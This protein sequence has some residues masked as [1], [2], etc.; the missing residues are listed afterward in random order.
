MN[1]VAFMT[2]DVES[3]Y[4]SELLKDRMNYDPKYSYEC[5]LKDY[6]DLLNKYNIKG[7]L[8]ILESSINNIKDIIKYAINSGHEIALHGK[9]HTSP[10]EQTDIEFEK[11]IKETKERLENEFNIEIKGY[12]A[13]CF[14]INDNKLQ[15]IKNL[16]FRI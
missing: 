7:T 4:D 14:G 16:G 3:L 11:E 15:I 12:R 2:I 6:I 10:F 13:P 9:R 8:F 1:K 5:Y